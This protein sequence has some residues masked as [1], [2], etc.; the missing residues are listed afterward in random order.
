[1]PGLSDAR[2]INDLGQ[3]VGLDANGLPVIRQPDGTIEVIP[4]AFNPYGIN[5]L[6]Q[7]IGTAG[8]VNSLPTPYIYAGGVLTSVNIPGAAGTPFLGI[9]DSGQIVGTAY[10]PSPV[11]FLYDHGVFRQM[12][13]GTGF[14]LARDV[15][16]AGVVAGIFELSNGN[17][18]GF[19]DD[20]RIGHTFTLAGATSFSFY[21]VNDSGQISGTAC[22]GS[23]SSGA[24]PQSG[25]LYTPR[26]PASLVFLPPNTSAY[27][28]NN[29]GQIVGSYTVP[30]PA[31]LWPS[32][33][34]LLGTFLYRIR[35]GRY[36]ALSPLR[37][38]ATKSNEANRL[39]PERLHASYHAETS[40]GGPFALALNVLP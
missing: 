13:F 25:F 30:E 17:V 2:G 24:S 31:L 34:L 39:T 27:G 18:A 38:A 19:L 8:S 35:V 9:N 37:Q 5:N 7:V 12:Q 28:L 32:A 4:F 29:A 21:G 15:N 14:T 33:V 3:I 22:F 36:V 10:L 1:L 26:E 20:H 23:C 16:N 6:G 40:G 11:G